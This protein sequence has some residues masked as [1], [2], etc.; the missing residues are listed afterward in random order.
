MMVDIAVVAIEVAARGNLHQK[1][2]D[3]CGRQALLLLARRPAMT[4]VHPIIA[5]DDRARLDRAEDAGLEPLQG[6]VGGLGGED[7]GLEGRRLI[8]TH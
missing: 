3:P 5:G 4:V 1:R 2:G 7:G 6:R 8:G